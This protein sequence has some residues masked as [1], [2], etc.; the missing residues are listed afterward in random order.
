MCDYSS[1][2]NN[3]EMGLP[4]LIQVLISQTVLSYERQ[5]YSFKQITDNN[6][7]YI[8][9]IVALFLPLQIFINNE[10]H[11]AVSGKKF[12]VFNPANEEKICEVEEG[13]KVGLSF[14]LLTLVLNLILH[15]KSRKQTSTSA[16][17]KHH[18]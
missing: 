2:Q 16:D 10:W 8:T 4:F 3:V 5:I 15:L 11:D 7:R 18:L 1:L 17:I 6:Y 9:N 13:D 12:E 14:L